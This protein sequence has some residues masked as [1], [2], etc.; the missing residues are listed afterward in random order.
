MAAVGHIRV[1]VELQVVPPAPSDIRVSL[2][3]KASVS[4]EYFRGYQAGLETARRIAELSSEQAAQHGLPPDL[5]SGEE[6]TE[7]ARGRSKRAGS[8][9]VGDDCEGMGV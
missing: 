7:S 1:P 4:E 5:G 2:G 3:F 6:T 8:S 9:C